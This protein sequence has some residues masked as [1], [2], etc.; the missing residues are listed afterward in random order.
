M[1]S[2]YS[3]VRQ[4]EANKRERQPWREH[5]SGCVGIIGTEV[6]YEG[7]TQYTG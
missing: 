4:A 5:R 3:D 7:M 6:I 2:G 1:P